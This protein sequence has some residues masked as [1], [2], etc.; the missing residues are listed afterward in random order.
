MMMKDC[1]PTESCNKPNVLCAYPK[2]AH[3]E[4]MNSNKSANPLEGFGI[5][6]KQQ[7]DEAQAEIARLKAELEL[8]TR[9]RDVL[10]QVAYL[11]EDLVANGETAY[12]LGNPDMSEVNLH[13]RYMDGDDEVWECLKTVY[14]DILFAHLAGRGE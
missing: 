1:T 2:C 9:E 5:I 14:S 11:L 8:R 7:W 12:I 6:S 4:Y 10:H 13:A 3:G